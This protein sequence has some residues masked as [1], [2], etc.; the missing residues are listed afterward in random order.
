MIRRKKSRKISR[1][2]KNKFRKTSRKRRSRAKRKPRHRKSRK[3]SR[4]RRRSRRRH[5][6]MKRKAEGV[7]SAG[8]GSRTKRRRKEMGI[9]V[10]FSPN[11][12]QHE[13]LGG[14]TGEADFY[15]IRQR[16]PRKYPHPHIYGLI[17][18][19]ITKVY[20]DENGM[21]GSLKQSYQ[22]GWK[23]IEF[24]YRP[25]RRVT[26]QGRSIPNL[27]NPGMPLPD[28]D[29]SC[30]GKLQVQSVLKTATRG[31]SKGTPALTN[32]F[33]F[34]IPNEIWEYINVGKTQHH[35]NDELSRAVEE[36]FLLALTVA[37]AD[38]RNQPKKN[39]G[40]VKD[41]ILNELEKFNEIWVTQ[42]NVENFKKWDGYRPMAW[43]WVSK[44]SKVNVNLLGCGEPYI[45]PPRQFWEK[46]WSLLTSQAR[47]RLGLFSGQ[48][49]KMNLS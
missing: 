49:P 28:L 8:H 37:H 20:T 22:G 48:R 40:S 39:K 11:S 5:F 2:R 6:R 4:R 33:F 41:F 38:P 18:G 10:H 44:E 46:L 42:E 15:K 16:P 12:N 29:Y 35:S 45:I 17:P 24:G 1:R 14:Y 36:V 9:F 7:E 32:I 21:V 3:K 47:S 13:I 34:K 19:E 23:Q 43:E 31:I 27:A 30:R 26:E 25:G